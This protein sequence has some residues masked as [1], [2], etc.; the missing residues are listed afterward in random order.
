[1]CNKCKTLTIPI[2]ATGA[3]GAT[4]PQGPVGPQGGFVHYIGEHF[5]GGIV[6]HLWKD[7][8]NV[9][10]GLIVSVEHVNSVVNYWS[11][12]PQIEIGPTA[13]S[14][15]NGL[16]NSNAIVSQVGNTF[17]AANA[18]LAYSKDG[19]TDWYLPAVDELSLLWNNR[20]NVNKTLST[21]S[22]AQL[23]GGVNTPTSIIYYWSSSE[24]SSYAAFYYNFFHGTVF[25]ENKYSDQGLY[26]RP[27]RQF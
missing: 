6:Y 27:I 23:L 19:F 11:D 8:Q 9:E 10:H 17:G 7:S 20:F 26:I 1:M 18:C 22:G 5:G 16:S 24:A 12:A 2:G 25:Y 15:W 14:S 4:G 3:T 21:I 13:K